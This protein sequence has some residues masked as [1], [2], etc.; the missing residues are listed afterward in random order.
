MYR[1]SIGWHAA[2]YP[3]RGLK[4]RAPDSGPQ[5]KGFDSL[6]AHYIL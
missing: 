1:H 3:R 5:V 6:Q 2:E 4:P